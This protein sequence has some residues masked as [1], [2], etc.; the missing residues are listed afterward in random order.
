VN[1]LAYFGER[2][3]PCGNC[4]TCLHPPVTWDATVPA[5]K[6]LSTVT[7]LD[8]ERRQRY[9]AGHIVDIL[10]GTR[11]PRV[12]QHHHDSLSTWGIGADLSDAEW[13]AVA[14]VLLAQGALTVA[15]GGHGVLVVTSVGVQV[16]RGERTVRARRDLP[17]ARARTAAAARGAG[18]VG[19]S[20]ADA[21]PLT[22]QEQELFDRLRAWRVGVAMERG[23]PAYVIFHDATLRAVARRRPATRD[24]LGGIVG[25]GQAKLDAYAE[26]LLDLLAS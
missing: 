18:R 17:V 5:Q 12:A 20:A 4:D 15:P 25:I 14:R 19:A 3:E 8:R 26:A 11:N 23:V 1:L 9:G 2:A 7:R 16:M 6:F 22:T 13:R 21:E 10:R 24:E